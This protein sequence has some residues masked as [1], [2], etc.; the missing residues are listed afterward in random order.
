MTEAPPSPAQPSPTQWVYAHAGL[1]DGRKLVVIDVHTLIGMQRYFLSADEARDVAAKM[2]ECADGADAPA[3]L[4]PV[5][6]LIGP[7]GQPIYIG[8]P[9]EAPDNSD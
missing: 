9:P 4:R 8:P 2:N 6:T 1:P 3:I 5:T 7:N